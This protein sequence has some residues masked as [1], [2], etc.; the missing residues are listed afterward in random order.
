MAFP[1]SSDQTR[2]GGE[3]FRVSASHASALLRSAMAISAELLGS[4]FTAIVRALTGN[5]GGT[6]GSEAVQRHLAA[7]GAELQ[8]AFFTRLQESQDQFLND[9][10]AAHSPG[11]G[12][13]L[14]SETLSLVDEFSVD[15]STVVDRLLDQSRDP[16]RVAVDDG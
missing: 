3:T 1:P 8:R 16:V 15:S 2:A 4:S 9:L 14:D 5:A 7:R 12:H 13:A 10:T 11:P 6:P